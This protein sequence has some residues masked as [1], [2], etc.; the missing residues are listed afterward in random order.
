MPYA[1]DNGGDEPAM[2]SANNKANK[3]KQGIPTLSPHPLRGQ[4]NSARCARN[5]YQPYDA[6]SLVVRL[7]PSPSDIRAASGKPYETTLGS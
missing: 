2:I 4:T 5:K 6:S 7:V 1:G 3:D